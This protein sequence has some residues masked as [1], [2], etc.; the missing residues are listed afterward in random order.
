M[1]EGE[2]RLTHTKSFPGTLT[3]DR[4]APLSPCNQAVAL[5]SEWSSTHLIKPSR[6]PGGADGLEGLATVPGGEVEVA[7]ALEE[8]VLTQRGGDQHIHDAEVWRHLAGNQV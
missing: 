8:D 1:P 2:A 4:R 7:S 5:L 3:E 6:V